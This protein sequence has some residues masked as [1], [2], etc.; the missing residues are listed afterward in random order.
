MHV[1]GKTTLQVVRDAHETHWLSCT[2][3]SLF[4]RGRA[5]ALTVNIHVLTLERNYVVSD[6]ADVIGVH[7]FLGDAIAEYNNVSMEDPT[8]G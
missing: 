3:V 1:D 2:L 7:E 4:H 8:D 6:H 5:K